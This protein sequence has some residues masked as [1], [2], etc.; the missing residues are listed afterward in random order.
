MTGFLT[1]Y[2]MMKTATFYRQWPVQ[3]RRARGWEGG[4]P[5]CSAEGGIRQAQARKLERFYQDCE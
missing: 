2:K 1:G 4:Q 5:V 3:A